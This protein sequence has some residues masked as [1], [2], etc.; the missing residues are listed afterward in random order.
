MDQEYL[1][2]KHKRPAVVD[3]DGKY[4]CWECYPGISD[5]LRKDKLGFVRNGE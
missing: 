1:C 4:Y 2:K 5:T 3:V